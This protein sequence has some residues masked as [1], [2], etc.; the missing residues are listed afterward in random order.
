MKPVMACNISVQHI[1]VLVDIIIF[2]ALIRNQQK[3]LGRKPVIVLLLPVGTHRVEIHHL[4]ADVVRHRKDNIMIHTVIIPR[5]KIKPIEIASHR[6][7]MANFLYNTRKRRLNEARRM[8]PEISNVEEAYKKMCAVKKI[9]YIFP[10]HIHHHASRK[11]RR[12]NRENI[13]LLCTSCGQN[14]V[15]VD[16]LCTRCKE[17]IQGNRYSLYCSSCQLTTYSVADPTEVFLT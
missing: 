3:Q 12:K 13:K 9:R 14:T 6:G 1:S 7:K 8:F 17:Y 15:T 10:E 16:L 4:P 2:P 5:N 11:Q